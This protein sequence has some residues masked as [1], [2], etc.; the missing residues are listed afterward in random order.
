MSA[1]VPLGPPKRGP[2]PWLLLAVILVLAA[3]GGGAAA[4]AGFAGNPPADDQ[5]GGGTPEPLAQPSAESN[6]LSGSGALAPRD[7]SKII[8]TG[9]M[10]LQVKDVVKA[11]D[12]ARAAVV[13]QGGYISA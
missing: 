4:P 12:A 5:S 13:D 2:R 9:T 7:D 3:C 11:V 1:T 6:D 10:Q 8:R